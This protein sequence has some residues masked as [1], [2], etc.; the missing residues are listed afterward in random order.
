MK[1]ERWRGIEETEEWTRGGG[2]AVQR[3]GFVVN[4]SFIV[5]FKPLCFFFWPL[6]F[7]VNT[8]S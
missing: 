1:L 5:V 7:F 3:G 8:L 6:M 4:M 2:G